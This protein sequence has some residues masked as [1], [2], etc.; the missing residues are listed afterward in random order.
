MF[1]LTKG[2]EQ[3]ALRDEDSVRLLSYALSD[4]NCPEAISRKMIIGSEPLTE[5]YTV[6]FD[7]KNIVTI[8]VSDALTVA[9][10]MFTLGVLSISITKEGENEDG[11]SEE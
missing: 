4:Y 6:S 5:N 11:K 10:W 3:V 2:L 9:S 8:S 1:I 7:E